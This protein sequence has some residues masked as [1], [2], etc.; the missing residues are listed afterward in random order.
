[1]LIADHAKGA[2][3]GSYSYKYID[4]SIKN[5]QLENMEDHIAGPSAG[6]IRP[7]GIGSRLPT[8]QTRTPFTPVDD[9]VLRDFVIAA[10]RQGVLVK[11]NIIYQQLA[12]IVREKFPME[13]IY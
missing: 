9:R 2:P 1:M 11:G 6:S 13:V 3:P 8:K 4:A 10:E 7:V 5:G 12:T